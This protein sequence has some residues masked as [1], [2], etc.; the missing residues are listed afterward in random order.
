M[1]MSQ[2]ALFD[3]L[4]NPN[5]YVPKQE[6]IINRLRSIY[7]MLCRGIK[8]CWANAEFINVSHTERACSSGHT[9]RC[10]AD[11]RRFPAQRRMVNAN[12][13]NG[14]AWPSP[15]AKK[16]KIFA[17]SPTKTRFKNAVNYLFVTLLGLAKPCKSR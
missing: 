11:T 2:L 5:A 10:I 17:F 9:A 16:P 14:W 6:H 13:V 8:R 1:P 15:L 7:A 3:D 12:K 4:P